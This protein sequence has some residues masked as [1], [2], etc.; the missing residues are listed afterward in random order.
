M[1]EDGRTVIYAASRFNGGDD[2]NHVVSI[3]VADVDEM[4]KAAVCAAGDL[5]GLT[6]QLPDHSIACHTPLQDDGLTI[7]TSPVGP[8]TVHYSSAA[9]E[10]KR[11]QAVYRLGDAW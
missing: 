9:Q 1:R 10:V 8:L 2:R 5:F 4:R 6:P 3:H 7:A 11:P